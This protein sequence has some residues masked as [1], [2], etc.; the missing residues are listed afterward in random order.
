MQQR[1]TRFVGLDVS[2]ESLDLACRPGPTRWQVRND[3]A[4][5]AQGRAPLR[6]RQPAL[7][8][9]EAT[10]GW[11]DALVA[12]LAVATLPVAGVNPRQ[13]RDVAKAPGP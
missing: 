3:S 11:P 8:V 13:M 2:Q 1:P 7:I 10:G 6:P 12:A 9:R 5:I 4:G